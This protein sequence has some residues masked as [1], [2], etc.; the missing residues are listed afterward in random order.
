[1]MLCVYV[2][3]C[4]CS[5]PISR[6]RCSNVAWNFS[7]YLLVCITHQE[8]SA[9]FLL[10]IQSSSFQNPKPLQLFLGNTSVFRQV[11][12]DWGRFDIISNICCTFSSNFFPRAVFSFVFSKAFHPCQNYLSP[13][14]KPHTHTH[15]FMPPLQTHTHTHTHRHI[16][17]L[18]W[19]K[20]CF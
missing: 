19:E 8:T 12:L 9:L 5:R 7:L 10:G 17:P 6:I 2:S 11:G 15:I 4:L 18:R 13:W 14:A 20:S 16:T 1:M 3:R